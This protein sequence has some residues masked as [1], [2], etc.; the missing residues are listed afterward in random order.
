MPSQPK[1]GGG[2]RKDN[3]RTR[4]LQEQGTGMPMDCLMIF[5]TPTPV[6]KTLRPRGRKGMERVYSLRMPFV[7]IMPDNRIL[8]QTAEQPAR[9]SINARTGLLL[10]LS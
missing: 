9:E 8:W 1:P 2:T 3:G 5:S 7:V 4:T 10:R 6:A